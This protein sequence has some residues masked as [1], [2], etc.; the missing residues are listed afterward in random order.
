MGY[1]KRPTLMLL[2]ADGWLDSGDLA[3][4]DAEGY[5]R[6]T[7]RTKDVL[8]RGGENVPVV[9]IENLLY[10]HPSV[11]SAAIVGFPDRRLGERACAFIV[12]RPGTSI[13][14]AEIHRYLA[15]AKTAKQYWPERVE[16]VNALP[17]TPTGKVQK[18][19]LRD[20]AK[21]FGDAG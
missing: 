14:L 17:L 7:G 2:D 11:A 10:K 4:V 8:I 1:Y 15:E 13:D 16:I 20:L 21:R 3:Q 12:P 6:I 18:Y 19:V 5:V 9:E